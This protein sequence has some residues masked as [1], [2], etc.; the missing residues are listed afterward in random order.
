MSCQPSPLPFNIVLEVQ[1]SL[2]KQASK[3]PA[4]NNQRK[5]NKQTTH[6]KKTAQETKIPKPQM[7]ELTL[8][9]G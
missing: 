9:K 7:K 6:N 1:I 8:E 2:V 5:K 4:N 3:Q